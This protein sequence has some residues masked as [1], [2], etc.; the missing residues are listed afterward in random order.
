MKQCVIEEIWYRLQ[1]G[2]LVLRHAPSGM[3]IMSSSHTWDTE[4]GHFHL[5][6]DKPKAQDSRTQDELVIFRGK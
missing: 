5:L 1:W 4:Q 6:Q 2:Q 3:G